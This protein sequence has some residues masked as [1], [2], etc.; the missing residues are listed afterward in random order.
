MIAQ[1]PS[2]TTVATTTTAINPGGSTSLTAT[3][4]GVAGALPPSGSVTV[5]DGT[6]NV[7]AGPV[8]AGKVTIAVTLQ[9]L[10]SHTLTAQYSGDSNYA[11]SSGTIAISVVQAF[12]LTSTAATVS[13]TTGGVSNTP[14]TITP[15][16]GFSGTVTLTCSSPVTYL[17]CRVVPLSVTVSGNTA[18]T[19]TVNIAA[20]P[21][22]IAAGERPGVPKNMT[23]LTLLLPL[24]LIGFARRSRVMGKGLLLMVVAA[25][26]SWSRA[27]VMGAPC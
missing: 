19:A 24:G 1:A 17:T 20:A 27:V 5:L 11:A 3:I 4:T 16:G 18:V 15:A 10:G 14:I 2:G 25:L 21:S 22:V 12:S 6:T 8:I 7:G 23:W 9:S 26:V 13:L